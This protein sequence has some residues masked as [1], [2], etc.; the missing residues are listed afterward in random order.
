MKIGR[1]EW[2][3]LSRLT[4]EERLAIAEGAI[5]QTWADSDNKFLRQLAEGNVA[6]FTAPP[7][8]Y[9]GP[10]NPGGFGPRPPEYLEHWRKEYKH[11][12]LY[13]SYHRAMVKLEQK[14][15]VAC[16]D[17]FGTYRTYS[18][19]DAGQRVVE[20]VRPI[21]E[22]GQPIRW[23]RVAKRIENQQQYNPPH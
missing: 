18:I 19:T 15:L 17:L 4:K 12:N 10:P 21:K 3:I 20:L 22:R 14:S 16:N 13:A 11:R 9:R 8:K 2:E 6:G 23:D 5:R 7:G 1:R